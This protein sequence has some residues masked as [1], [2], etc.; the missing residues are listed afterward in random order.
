MYI[1]RCV[2]IAVIL[3]VMV[4]SCSRPVERDVSENSNPRKNAPPVSQAEQNSAANSNLGTNSAGSDVL[5]KQCVATKVGK[6][7]VMKSQTFPIDFEPF[8]GSCFVTT[9]DPE[10]PD[11]PMV[12]HYSIFKNGI[13]IFDF[14]EQFNNATFGC[15]VDAV[16]FQDLNQ[17]NLKDVIVVGKCSTKAVPYNENTV[18]INTG[19]TFVTRQDGNDRLGDFTNVK[20]IA[21]FV[22]DNQ[23]IFYK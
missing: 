9:Y 3:C 6:D 14:P 23:Q 10:Y 7:A 16:A 15:W 20:E 2:S 17:D 19:K 4:C 13:K 1:L 12:S 5:R 8:A 22:E 11:P 18:Y 21:D